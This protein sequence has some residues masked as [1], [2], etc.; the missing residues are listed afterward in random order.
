MRIPLPSLNLSQEE[1]HPLTVFFVDT[2]SLDGAEK[3]ECRYVRTSSI[4]SCPKETV[5]RCNFLNI[6][7]FCVRVPVLSVSRYEIRPSSSG[8]V[9]V[10]TT[11]S[12]M[13]LSR[14]II[15]EYT[16]FAMSR[17]ILKLKGIVAF[18]ADRTDYR[19]N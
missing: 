11:V 13:S 17:L 15:H 18:K 16:S 4:E 9:L 2:V 1:K 3:T 14:E 6:I 5:P 19:R 12:G 7:S 10:R 8:M